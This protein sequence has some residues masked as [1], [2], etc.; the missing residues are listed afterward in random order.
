MSAGARFT[1]TRRGGIGN[2]AFARAALTR[3]RLSFTP[4]AGSPTIVHC[5]NPSA[6]S[7]STSTSNAS[8]PSMAADRTV[9]SMC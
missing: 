3:S 8:M 9:A 5:G 7:T 1:V 2:P 4:P 6:T